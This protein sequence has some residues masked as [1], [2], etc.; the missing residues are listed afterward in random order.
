M[1][2]HIDALATLVDVTF[3][4]KVP[5]L[6]LLD[7]SYGPFGRYTTHSVPLYFAL[8]LADTQKGFIQ[9]PPFLDLNTLQD[10]IERE[11]GVPDPCPTHP[12]LFDIASCLL[13]VFWEQPDAYATG[14]NGGAQILAA[15]QQAI[16]ELGEIRRQKL[17]ALVTPGLHDMVPINVTNA[18]EFELQTLLP[19]LMCIDNAWQM[20]LAHSIRRRRA[21]EASAPAPAP[22]SE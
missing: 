15:T 13:P 16:E 5:A 17:R 14:G 4:V 9:I 20:Q 19:A 1:T 21:Q 18:T 6:R 2:S 11:R 7:Q 8:Q 10:A 12:Y 3:N 22:T